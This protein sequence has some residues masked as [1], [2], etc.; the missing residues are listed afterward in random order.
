MCS[1]ADKPASPDQ[2]G[3]KHGLFRNLDS[4]RASSG[5][6]DTAHF[7]FEC[8]RAT[9]PT[10]LV[11]SLHRPCSETWRLRGVRRDREPRLSDA[12]RQVKIPALTAAASLRHCRYHRRRVRRQK[13]SRQ[14][15]QLWDFHRPL[16]GAENG[17]PSFAENR[18][19]PCRA[20]SSRAAGNRSP[21][22]SAESARRAPHEFAFDLPSRASRT[23]APSVGS[24]SRR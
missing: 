18:S 12:H 10:P 9:P 15:D 24:L 2:N 3:A 5:H 6:V 17:P 19:A 14:I 22:R 16:I 13:Q 7:P 23:A 8:K 1:R 21:V 11:C 4:S 20:S